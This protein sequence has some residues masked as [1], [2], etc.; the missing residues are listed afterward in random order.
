[1]NSNGMEAVM[2]LA[3]QADAIT[4]TKDTQ[5]GIKKQRRSSLHVFVLTVIRNFCKI[6]T[7]LKQRDRHIKLNMYVLIN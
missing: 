3:E 2:E 7:C 6:L 1:M 4:E 5:V